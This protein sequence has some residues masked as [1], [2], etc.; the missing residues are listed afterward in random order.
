MQVERIMLNRIISGERVRNRQVT[1]LEHWNSVSR[2]YFIQFRDFWD[3]LNIIP[4]LF[5]DVSLWTG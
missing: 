4:R 5:L 1:Y 2:T 3:Y